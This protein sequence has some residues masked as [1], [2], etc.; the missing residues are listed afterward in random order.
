MLRLLT[1]VVELAC[2]ARLDQ[3]DAASRVSEA[4]GTNGDT[5]D[6]HACDEVAA[7]VGIG[8]RVTR[9]VATEPISDVEMPAS[10]LVDEDDDF[11]WYRTWPRMPSMIYYAQVA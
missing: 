11:S 4:Y 5:V 3:T 2:R 8:S 9:G 7:V 10:V 6:D 1:Q